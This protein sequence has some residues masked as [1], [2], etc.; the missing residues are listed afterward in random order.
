MEAKPSACQ[1]A[2]SAHGIMG[3]VDGRGDSLE[4]LR[5]TNPKIF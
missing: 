2:Q 3:S 5:N 1:G 4:N